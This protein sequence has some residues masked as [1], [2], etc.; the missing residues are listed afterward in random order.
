MTAYPEYLR[1]TAIPTD[2]RSRKFFEDDETN[3]LDEGILD[4]SS[5]ESPDLFGDFADPEVVSAHASNP[6]YKTN[7]F[8]YGQAPEPWTSGSCTP[9]TTAFDAKFPVETYEGDASVMYLAGAGAAQATA[10]SVAFEAQ[11][12]TMMRQGSTAFPSGSSTT[13]VSFPP[14]P[15]DASPDWM[16]PTNNEA[17]HARS[18]AKRMRHGSPSQSHSPLLRRGDG[19]RKKNARFEIPAE[20]NLHNIDHFIAQS[21]DDQEIKELKQQKRLLRNRQAA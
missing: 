6:F 20:R 11:A 17:T 3:V 21:S 4:G 7:P 19:I 1:P 15:H 9:T 5:L 14:S 18:M 12:P 10:G 8:G 13:T 16:S 2:A